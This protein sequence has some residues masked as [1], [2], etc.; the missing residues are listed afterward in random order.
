MTADEQNLWDRIAERAIDRA[1]MGTEAW[2]AAEIAA[3]VAD[4][5]V[6]ERR[7]RKAAEGAEG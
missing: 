2:R 1:M 3:R 4:C 7:K 6:E 5:L